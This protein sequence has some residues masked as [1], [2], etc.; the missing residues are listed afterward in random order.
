MPALRPCQAGAWPLLAVALPRADAALAVVR[1]WEAGEAVLPLD[2]AAPAAALRRTLA[3][4]RPPTCWTA[5]GAPS[6]P[7]ASRWT[8]RSPRSWPPPAPAVLDG[9][10][11][12]RPPLHVTFP[13][14]APWDGA[15]SMPLPCDRLMTCRRPMIRTPTS[16]RRRTAGAIR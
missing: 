16:V 3:A 2:P 6:C 9:S 7:A 15:S 14:D 5:T 12:S 1:A 10:G 4:L 11:G 13:Q 8:T